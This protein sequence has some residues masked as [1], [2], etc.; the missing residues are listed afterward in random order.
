MPNLAFGWL[1]IA[2]GFVSGAVIGLFF[3]RPD[4]LGGYA[5]L[6]RRLVRLGHISFFG[7]GLI[8]ILFALSLPHARLA[9]DEAK[10]A[11]VAMIVGGFA[12]PICCG[13]VA[14]RERLHPLFVV[15]VA[16]LIYGG[17]A[18]ARGLMAA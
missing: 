13:L 6:P 1:W 4:W 18:L 15:P 8:N 16:A 9:A 2:V 17:V 7:L 14:W 11:G 12:M 10:W 3:R 5:A